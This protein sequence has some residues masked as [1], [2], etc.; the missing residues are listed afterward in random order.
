MPPSKSKSK[1]RLFDSLT[2]HETQAEFHSPGQR[3]FPS[4]HRNRNRNRYRDKQEDAHE[5]LKLLQLL[6][7]RNVNRSSST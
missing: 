6:R 2:L 4:C 7:L 1:C 5:Q 3:I